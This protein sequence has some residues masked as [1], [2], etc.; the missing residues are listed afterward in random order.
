MP[1]MEAARNPAAT[2][3]TSKTTISANTET[4]A[5]ASRGTTRYWRESIPIASRARTSPSTLLVASSA[6]IAVPERPATAS[7]VIRGPNS[8]TMATTITVPIRSVA[9]KV[10]SWRTSWEMT[11]KERMPESRTKS[12]TAFTAVNRIWLR[13]TRNATRRPAADS[14]KP[15]RRAPKPKR[16]SAPSRESRRAAEPPSRAIGTITGGSGVLLPLEPLLGLRVLGEDGQRLVV[17]LDRLV[18]LPAVLVEQGARVVGQGFG[19]HLPAHPRVGGLLGQRRQVHVLHQTGRDVGDDPEELVAAHHGVLGF[20]DLRGFDVDQ[21]DVHPEVAG[22]VD[23][24]AEDGILGADQL[25]DLGGG[26][27]VHPAG[28]AQVLLVEQLLHLLALDHAPG[29][30]RGELGDEHPRNA[31]LEAG[32]VEAVLPDGA[33]VLEFEDGD[34][35][36]GIGGALR[37]E[38]AE[39]Q[40]G[41]RQQSE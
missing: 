41:E 32:E 3:P 19:R 38:P 29:G 1:L 22:E 8:R 10:P 26:L 5:A 35:G 6:E 33:T 7:A 14:A 17:H 11:R 36:P 30:V 2:A 23:E 4:S 12:P 20:H 25:A 9:P 40:A 18:L 13:V 16:A 37:G 34:A 15:A 31:A 24:G 28:R 27:R 39:R 21:A